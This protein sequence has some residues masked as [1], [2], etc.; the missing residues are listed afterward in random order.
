M[1]IISSGYLRYAN[2]QCPRS[3]RVEGK[4]YECPDRSINLIITR[5]TYFYTVGGSNI[6]ELPDSANIDEL[7]TAENIRRLTYQFDDSMQESCSSEFIN[8]LDI[9]ENLPK[10]IYTDEDNNDCSICLS[11]P[12][13]L[14]YVPCG[15]FI[16]C[17]D[18]DNRLKNSFN[19]KCPICRTNIT[20]A[21]SYDLIN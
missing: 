2:C 3:I 13:V 14:V 7:L 9:I 10:K 21:I 12:K 8:K 19:R 17:S 20:N 4:F 11:A 6:K 15:H 5:N 16:S 18:C 1:K